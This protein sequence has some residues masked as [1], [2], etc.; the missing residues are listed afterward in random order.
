MYT[1]RFQR[2][3]Q[4]RRTKAVVFTIL[5]NVALISSL[6]LLTNSEASLTEFVQS[7]FEQEAATHPIERP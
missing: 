7:F 1:N 6:L 2:N 3:A 4:R 5:I